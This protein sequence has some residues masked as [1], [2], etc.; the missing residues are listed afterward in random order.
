MLLLVFNLCVCF[1]WWKRLVFYL[2]HN[3]S[4]VWIWFTS[5]GSYY[6]RQTALNG[7]ERGEEI[8]H[9]A[10]VEQWLKKCLR[11]P[12]GSLDVLWRGQHLEQRVDLLLLSTWTTEQWISVVCSSLWWRLQCWCLLLI[13]IYCLVVSVT[14]SM[15]EIGEENHNRSRRIIYFKSQF[16]AV[17]LHG[18]NLQINTILRNY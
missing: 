4:G 8:D 12:Y 15:G 2:P 13:L 11:H 6:R 14:I 9:I 16:V 5:F 10:L 7:V 17:E 1:W 18:H 3:V